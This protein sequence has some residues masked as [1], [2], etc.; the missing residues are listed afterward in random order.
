MQEALKHQVDT[1]NNLR[2]SCRTYASK[3]TKTVL[4]CKGQVTVTNRW[5]SNSHQKS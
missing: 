4:R 1:A 3:Y 5:K 2:V